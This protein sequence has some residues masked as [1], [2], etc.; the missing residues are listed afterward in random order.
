[1]NLIEKLKNRRVLIVGDV[2]ID[3]Y[4]HGS[5]TRI[6]PEAPVP[7][8]NF[9]KKEDRLGGAGNVALNVQS[10]GS[11]AI[12]CSVVGEDLLDNWVN[13][14]DRNKLPTDGLTFSKE[15]VSTVKTRFI[16]NNQ[17]MLR[18]D[19]ETT[20]DITMKMSG[21]LLEKIKEII[22]N[23]RPDVIILQDYN[24]G[25]LT[26]NLIESIIKLA[27]KNKI[28]I[29]VDP[30]KKNFFNYK[31]ATLFKPNL[32]EIREA[33][34]LIIEPTVDSLNVAA[35]FLHEKLGHSQTMVTLSDKGI[36]TEKSGIGTIW[37]TKPRQVADV[38]GAGDTVI[39]VAA[40]GLAAELSMPEIAR[41]SNI[42]GGQ[43]CETL[44][45]VAVDLDKFSKEVLSEF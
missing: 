24:K 44:G 19:Q 8:L 20:D 41:L 39:A 42:A 45:V 26:E 21:L 10:L 40:L 4:V 35:T 6:S 33:T 11:E 28:P 5:V 13:L 27:I 22:K 23:N 30:K 2:M 14:F 31:N 9:F 37:P 16:G 32:K 3:R 12:I 34:G 38:S 36:Y 17:Q 25:V 43:V 18:L 29:A 1:M 15:R 7:V